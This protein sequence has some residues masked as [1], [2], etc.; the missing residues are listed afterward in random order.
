MDAHPEYTSILSEMS[1][2]ALATETAYLGG[3]KHQERSLTMN[4]RSD[5]VFRVYKPIFENVSI[6]Y[7]ANLGI[8]RYSGVNNEQENRSGLTIEGLHVD[9]AKKFN[10]SPRPSNYIFGVSKY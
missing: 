9:C 5:N 2:L 1:T 3:F 8:I 10:L 7:P 4:T 6:I